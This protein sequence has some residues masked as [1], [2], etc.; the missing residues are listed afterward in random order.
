MESYDAE[1][2]FRQEQIKQRALLEG[3]DLEYLGNGPDAMQPTESRG[4]GRGWLMGEQLVFKCTRCGYTMSADMNSYDSCWCGAMDKDPD[5]GRF[6]SRLGDAAIEV[7][8][9]ES[10]R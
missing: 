2:G 6:G 9:T 8:R 10:R 4:R 1:E 7:Y 5:Y 3:R